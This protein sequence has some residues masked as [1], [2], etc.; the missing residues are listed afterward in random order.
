MEA[1]HSLFVRPRPGEAAVQVDNE[2]GS[3]QL[4]ARSQWQ[5][6]S[7]EAAGQNRGQLDT[8]SY[9]CCPP[10]AAVQ[11]PSTAGESQRQQSRPCSSWHFSHPWH[12]QQLSAAGQM[13]A[14]DG[15]SFNFCQISHRVELHFFS[16][17]H[18]KD[19]HC[20]WYIAEVWFGYCGRWMGVIVIAI[21]LGS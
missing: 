12:C 20:F 19:N 2:G 13:L 21:E 6:G 1:I 8:G 5:A 14:R 7:S 4:E 16:C 15:I 10:A 9:T 11:L 17:Q 3:H 18:K